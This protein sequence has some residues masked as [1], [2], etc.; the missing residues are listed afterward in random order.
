MSAGPAKLPPQDAL[1]ALINARAWLLRR[2]D[3][4]EFVD[5]TSVQRTIVFTLDLAELSQAL[6][7]GAREF[8]LGLFR[9]DAARPG[10][11]L[12]DASGTVVAHMSRPA[13]DELVMRLVK[14]R[15]DTLSLDA[16]VQLEQIRNH[17]PRSCDLLM[18]KREFDPYADLAAEKWGCPAVGQ[19]LARLRDAKLESDEQSV[20]V[21]EVV[22]LLFDWQ[23]N[24]VLFVPF[25]PAK[26]PSDGSPSEPKSPQPRLPDRLATLT[27]EYDEELRV[28]LTP[29]D[30]RRSALGHNDLGDEAPAFRRHI[31]RT[32]FRA[33][34]DALRP[35]RPARWVA[36]SRWLWLRR[37]GRRGSAWTAWHVA[38][39][40]ASSRDV[41]AH[42][43][44][45]KMPADLAVIR[46]RMIESWF[47]DADGGGRE[48]RERVVAAELSRGRAAILPVPP[49]RRDRTG[50][51][52]YSPKA[53]PLT[54]MFMSLV[55]AQQRSSGPWLAAIAAAGATGLAML[56]GAL[57]PVL[58]QLVAQAG[59]VVTIL[60]LAPTLV[61]A[62]LSVRASSDIAQELT[63]T[64]RV[65]VARLR[66]RTPLRPASHDLARGRRADDCRRADP[67]IRLVKARQA[68][69]VPGH[70]H[71]RRSGAGGRGT[72]PERG[73]AP[74]DPTTGSLDRDRRGRSGPVGMAAG[75]AGR[76]AA[77]GDAH[78][79]GR[80][81]E[82]LGAGVP[83][84]Q[85]RRASAVDRLADRTVPF[86]LT[87]RTRPPSLADGDTEARNNLGTLLEE[88]GRLEN[89]L[90]Q[91]QAGKEVGDRLA[92]ENAERLSG[93]LHRPSSAHR[94][95]ERTSWIWRAARF[96]GAGVANA[97]TIALAAAAVIVYLSNE[98]AAV[99]VV[100]LECSIMVV[101][102]AL[103]I[104]R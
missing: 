18:T 84:Q 41:A 14:A 33:D 6:P 28:W 22:R 31:G 65:L 50:A 34:L 70:G 99:A 74:A 89:A 63:Q 58:P 64:L 55:V 51:H 48:R 61:S 44:E 100:A 19:L 71:G 1:S 95:R 92:A 96:Y 26:A 27:Y 39:Q 94:S 37:L 83:E 104:R 88:E 9:R 67:E 68:A 69:R 32:P 57:P 7:D 11:R 54:E 91:Y 8:P 86:Q 12:T 46:M 15:L 21:A 85:Q 5:L 87:R 66:A 93:H 29:W 36:W 45:V 10:A 53:S 90:T 47:V 101:A 42:V 20:K 62:L 72:D 102:L 49:L 59:A 43:V 24:F 3:Q 52:D 82:V 56:A 73:L 97:L 81:L 76:R 2:V 23:N 35:G 38:W 103:T 13:S 79:A 4:L 40:Q 98:K 80:G 25:T 17:S 16:G 60:L 78:R 77:A 75:D 30:R